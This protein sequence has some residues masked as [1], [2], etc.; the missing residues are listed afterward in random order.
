MLL[1]FKGLTQNERAHRIAM[2]REFLRRSSPVPLPLPASYHREPP[3]WLRA[4]WTPAGLAPRPFEFHLEFVEVLLTAAVL[5]DSHDVDDK[6]LL[7]ISGEEAEAA[8]VGG[9]KPRR[10]GDTHGLP[11]SSRRSWIYRTAVPAKEFC[12]VAKNNDNSTVS[13]TSVEELEGSAGVLE[14]WLPDNNLLLQH[15]LQPVRWLPAPGALSQEGICIA[16]SGTLGRETDQCSAL[17]LVVRLCYA[18]SPEGGPWDGAAVPE[19]EYGHRSPVYLPVAS[20]GGQVEIILRS[21]ID[22]YVHASMITHG[23]SN[24]YG[25]PY[26]KAGPVGVESR[27]CGG[28]LQRSLWHRLFEA[29]PS[30]GHCFGS[31]PRYAQAGGLAML[32]LGTGILAL[33]ALADDAAATRSP[34]GRAKSNLRAAKL[35]MSGVG[36]LLLIAAML[37]HLGLFGVLSRAV[38]DS[39]GAALRTEV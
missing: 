39:P 34:D 6:V 18:L 13:G 21:Q 25:R 27:A 28:Q 8:Q 19:C 29:D 36:A 22:A 17:H 24:C 7:P 12:N 10:L 20:S 9:T 33:S 38:W 1:L 15:V 16:P 31:P 37:A 4:T 3:G 14:V 35:W 30:Q 11:K 5:G 32:A 23:C 2:F 26:G